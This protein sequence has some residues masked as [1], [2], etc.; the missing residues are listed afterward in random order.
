MPVFTIAG[1]TLFISGLWQTLIFGSETSATA[2]VLFKKDPVHPI[3]RRWVLPAAGP[4]QES[5]VA[6]RGLCNKAS[7]TRGALG[8]PQRGVISVTSI[9]RQRCVTAISRRHQPLKT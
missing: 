6:G 4:M 5:I 2:Y 9:S 7:L 1:Y 3:P 8:S